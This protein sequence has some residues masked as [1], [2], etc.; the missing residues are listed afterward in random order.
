LHHLELRRRSFSG[1]ACLG[2]VF[3]TPAIVRAGYR[4]QPRKHGSLS[5]LD[6]EAA[7]KSDLH[8]YIVPHVP[9]SFTSLVS[10]WTAS[11]FLY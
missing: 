6:G 8:R 1:R 11:L 7:G 2:D 5:H 9:R 10:R 3:R 4:R